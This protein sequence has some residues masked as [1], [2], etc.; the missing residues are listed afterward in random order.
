M[1]PILYLSTSFS[2]NRKNCRKDTSNN[3]KDYEE[4]I[5]K[6]DTK[7]LSFPL[8]ISDIGKLEKWNNLS[9]NVFTPTSSDDIVPLRISDEQ[10]GIPAERIIDLLYIANGNDTHYC[11]ITNLSSLCR[12]QVT[13]DHAS[14]KFLCRRC[15][16]FC[17]TG[18]SYKSHLETCSQHKAQKTVYPKKNDPKGRDKVRLTKIK[19]QHPLPF[20][21]TADFESRLEKVGTCVN[22]PMKSG[23]TVLNTHIPCGAAYMISCTDPRFYEEPEMITPDGTDTNIAERFLDSILAKA[24]RLREMLKYKVPIK[25]TVEEKAAF[26]DTERTHTCHIC[27]RMIKTGE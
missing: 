11:L 23:S 5:D 20:F 14:S 18:Q 25:W 16:H 19:R 24:K 6:I 10:E 4:H 7:H 21:F 26:Q 8:L 12:S 27:K 2:K 13:T 17:A 22:D 9:I 1:C 3:P 15:L